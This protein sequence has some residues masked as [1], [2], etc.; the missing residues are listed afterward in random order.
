MRTHAHGIGV[1]NSNCSEISARAAASAAAS[2][3]DSPNNNNNTHLGTLKSPSS[4]SGRTVTAP[5]PAS[6]CCLLTRAAMASSSPQ[7][8]A[9]VSSN[10]PLSRVICA[11]KVDSPVKRLDLNVWYMRAAV[12]D[13]IATIWIHL[14]RVFCSA[15]NLLQ[16]HIW[17]RRV[18]IHAQYNE[19]RTQ[20]SAT[21][22]CYRAVRTCASGCERGC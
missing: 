21:A 16:Y 17:Y 20:S 9:N 11:R 14:W 19:S 5:D 10:G 3:V 18:S 13:V 15:V 12:I 22:V 2:R 1:T 4:H 7:N 6:P 8:W